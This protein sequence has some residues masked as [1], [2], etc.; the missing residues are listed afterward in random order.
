MNKTD[1]IFNNIRRKTPNRT[2]NQLTSDSNF[3]SIDNAWSWGTIQSTSGTT[4]NM[5]QQAI[6]KVTKFKLFGMFTF[7]QTI[8]EIPVDE[9]FGKI[10]KNT[11]EIAI[12]DTMVD[13]YK[14]S[15]EKA[16]KFG[17]IALAEKLEDNI[18]IV[19]REILAVTNGVTQYLEKVQVD[20]LMAK[21]SKNIELTFIK[22]FTRPIPEKF[23]EKVE[24][25]QADNVFDDY[26]VMHY[27]PK[28]ENSELTKKEIEKKKDPILFGLIHGSTNM[29]FIGDWVDEYC[30]LTLEEAVAIIEDKTKV[31]YEEPVIKINKTK[32]K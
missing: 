29:Y 4:I 12:I 17:Q 25:L 28:N 10:K 8:K 16:R 22:N 24:K 20:K 7:W 15:I 6:T 18:E 9:F 27:D 30:N 19:Q 1:S 21:S 23:L 3:V 14:K 2:A 13:K 5:N 32:K 31:L 26:V 11:K